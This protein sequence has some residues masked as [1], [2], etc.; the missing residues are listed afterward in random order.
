M[1]GVKATPKKD[2]RS[3]IVPSAIAKPELT[4]GEK[5]LAPG[6]RGRE[7]KTAPLLKNCPTLTSSGL[8]KVKGN[9]YSLGERKR[10]NDGQAPTP[11]AR[12]AWRNTR[13]KE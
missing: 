7:R 11:R 13:D 4:K 5:K 8:G 3:E 1:E 10:G 12:S 2:E 9:W 6:G